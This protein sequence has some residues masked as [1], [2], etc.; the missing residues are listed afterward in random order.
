MTMIVLELNGLQVPRG[1]YPAVQRNAAVTKDTSRKVP[2]PVVITAKING[3]PA[4]ALLDS[5]SL[6]DFMSSLGL[7]LAVQGSRSKINF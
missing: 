2:R 7:Q 1:T 5:G 3:H 4:R 6:G